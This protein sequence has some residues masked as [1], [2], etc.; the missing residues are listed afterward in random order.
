MHAP[1]RATRACVCVC[2]RTRARVRART[3][4]RESGALRLL[5]CVEY[6]IA[7]V[8]VR[9]RARARLAE[10][11]SLSFPHSQGAASHTSVRLLLYTPVERAAAN[12]N[13]SPGR[14]AKKKKI[15]P[16]NAY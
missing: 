7:R 6:A 4:E 15:R 10:E 14:P 5:S 11:K 13:N 2:V 3:H 16:R 9:A 8:R 12:T 1:L